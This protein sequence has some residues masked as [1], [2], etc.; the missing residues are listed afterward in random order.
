M[1][2]GARGGLGR[3]IADELR[4]RGA[5]VLGAGRSDVDI[6]CDLRDVDAGAAVVRG[7]LGT[8]GR[9]DGVV[10]AAGIVAFGDVVDTEPVVIE[11]LFL[12]NALG[13]LWLARAV[14]PTLSQTKGF[15]VN[16]SG[17]VAEQSLPHMVA[18]CASKA[19]ASHAVPGLRREA[20]RLGVH[21]V[22]ARPP[23]TE[24]GLATRPVAGRAPA[25]GVGLAPE[26]VARRIVDAIANDEPEVPSTAFS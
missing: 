18:Y 23:H 10:N 8:Q 5:I 7:A 21:V 6:V 4:R 26:A 1:V 9:L 22:D 3:P 2:V 25:F 15:F 11:E 12:T 24:T 19:A 13:P 20:R 14:L 17:V 16:V